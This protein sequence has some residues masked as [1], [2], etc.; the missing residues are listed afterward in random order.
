VSRVADV[1]T[2]LTVAE[3]TAGLQR[4]RRNGLGRRR[5]MAAALWRVS[6]VGEVEGRSAGAQMREGE[7]A[8]EVLGSSGRGRGGCERHARRGRGVRGTRSSG[9]RLRGDGG[10]DS[11]GPRA[12]R[13]GEAS[14]DA[15][16]AVA[17]TGG[18]ARAEREEGEGRRARGD[19]LDGPKGRGGGGCGLLSFFLLFW[20]LFSLF[21]LFTLFDSNLNRPQIQ[22]STS[23]Y[24]APNKSRI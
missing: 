18:P 16:K 5:L 1:G 20:H 11:P 13:A 12:E 8:S 7:R 23:K 21:F 4:R 24:Y 10:A 3:G 6:G 9:R 14:A 19:G 2:K 17:L 22:I 15:R